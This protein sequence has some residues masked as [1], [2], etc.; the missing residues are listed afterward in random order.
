M[1]GR[2][3]ILFEPSVANFSWNYFLFGVYISPEIFPLPSHLL[4]TLDYSTFK[5][6]RDVN[7]KVAR[8]ESKAAW[9]YSFPILLT[10]MLNTTETIFFTE[11]SNLEINRK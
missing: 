6:I 9:I 5:K 4:N 3:G 11:N 10:E 1:S 8:S 7:V 2:S